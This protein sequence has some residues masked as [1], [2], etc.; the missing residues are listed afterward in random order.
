MLIIKYLNIYYYFSAI[1]SENLENSSP[2]KLLQEH[3]ITSSWK[4]RKLPERKSVNGAKRKL[5]LEYQDI[6]FHKSFVADDNITSN[7]NSDSNTDS[8]DEYIPS[9]NSS[10]NDDDC[11][12]SGGNKNKI[13]DSKCFDLVNKN[14]KKKITS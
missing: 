4:K 9:E 13:Q 6:H 3:S 12:N 14:I 1:H 2:S 5:D 11:Q 7:I 10:E 8:G